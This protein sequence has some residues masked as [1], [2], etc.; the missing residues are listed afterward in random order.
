MYEIWLAMN[1]FWE[2]AMSI[3]PALL[4][5]ALAWIALVVVALRRPGARW[6]AGLGTAAIAGIGVMLVSIVV[7]PYLTKSSLAEMGYWV[8]WANLAAIGAGF[9]AIAAAYVWPL[10]AMRCGAAASAG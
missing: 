9:G 2:I 1:I 4:V 7:V 10:A 8:D 3:W 6:R 5:A